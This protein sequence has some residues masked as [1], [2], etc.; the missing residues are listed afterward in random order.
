MCA[1]TIPGISL[2]GTNLMVVTIRHP[3]MSS[4]WYCVL[5]DGPKDNDVVSARL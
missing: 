2:K 1:E 4:A 5:L 3:F